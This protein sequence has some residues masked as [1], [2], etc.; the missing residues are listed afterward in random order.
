[1]SFLLGAAL[2][3]RRRT[4]PIS[5]HSFLLVAHEGALFEGIMLLALTLALG[6]ADLRPGLETFAAWLL[7]AA[8]GFSVAS[9][10]TNW[11]KGVQDQFAERS[12]GLRLAVI[13]ALLATTGITIILVGVIKGL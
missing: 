13:N 6:L 11:R 7:V 8:S 9:A 5:T 2:A 3:R 4:A 12:A 1:M 10:L